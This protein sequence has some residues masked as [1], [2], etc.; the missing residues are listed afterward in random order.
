MHRISSGVSTAC[1]AG[2]MFYGGISGLIPLSRVCYVFFI[3]FIVVVTLTGFLKALAVV[4][5]HDVQ[6]NIFYYV[7]IILVVSVGSSI[8]I[9]ALYREKQALFISPMP[10][11]SIQ[12]IHLTMR[13]DF[14]LLP[15]GNLSGQGTVHFCEDATGKR[16]SA[17]GVINL[18]V[19]DSLSQLHSFAGQGSSLVVEGSL[20][21]CKHD[22]GDDLSVPTFYVQRVIQANTPKGL[23]YMRFVIRKTLWESFRNQVWAGFAIALLLG[24]RDDLDQEVSLLF[25]RAGSAHVLALSGMH[26][27]IIAAFLAFLLRRPLGVRPSSV[28]S[29]IVL[30]L[31]VNLVGFQPSLIRS[32]IMYMLLM[33]C[34][35]KG[36]STSFISV[37]ALSFLIQLFLDPL[38]MASLSAILSYS[39]LVGIVLLGPPILNVLKGWVP[40]PLAGALATSLGAFTV[41]APLVTAYFGVLYPIGILAGSIL[42]LIVSLFMLGSI[43]FLVF[44]SF[45][46]M[47][48][49]L[50]GVVLAYI[51]KFQL[52]MLRKFADYSFEIKQVHWS[53]VVIFSIAMTALFVYGHYRGKEKR[54]ISSFT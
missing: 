26:I 38:G 9:V 44:F 46:P 43:L 29:L 2:L 48:S 41:T 6:R 17:R 19:S 15:K 14:R 35:F 40:L 8:G 24:V 50:I 42:G 5:P 52:I 37:I 51:Y 45:L 23:E 36:I 32:L 31:Y 13:T 33:F 4:M 39:A 25:H 53:L 47:I 11:K 3:V 20:L 18:I 27:G 54:T 12:K 21:P 22:G 16:I 7:K 34:F 10:V 28:V 30:F 49:A 1:G